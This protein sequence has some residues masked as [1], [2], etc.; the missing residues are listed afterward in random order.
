M[1][2]HV[3]V[4][5]K[6]TGYKLQVA[7]LKKEHPLKMRFITLPMRLIS[8]LS[9]IAA[10]LFFAGSSS[11]Q[12]QVEEDVTSDSIDIFA[13][14]KEPEKAPAVGMIANLVLPGLGHLWM[15][16]QKAA[17]G[18]LTAEALFIFGAFTTNQY[19]HELSRSAR[20]FA[21]AY[22]NVQGG[23]GASD[24]F[25]ENVGKFMDSDG[26]NQ[27]R[28]LGF[29]QIMGLNYRWDNEKYLA[30]NLQWRWGSEPF[31]KHYNDL[32]KKSL[33]YKVAS[34]FCLGAMLLNRIVS[35]VDLRVAS[36]HQGKGLFSNLQFSS[37]VNPQTGASS[38]AC[39]APF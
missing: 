18:Y 10:F 13:K 2:P 6:V 24:F 11:A 17:L 3:Q 22:A 16:D 12:V 35:F 39:T 7:G 20:S 28:P 19:S 34:N 1:R 8:R 26:L 15:G 5:K 33:R 14:G 21:F 29:N 30:P 32:S 25:W 36:R 27:S 23:P 38:V 31:R 37:S 4:L 9:L